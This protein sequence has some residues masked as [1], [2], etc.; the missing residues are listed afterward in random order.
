MEQ[1]IN[2]FDSSPKSG[3]QF[4]TIIITVAL[5]ALVVGGGIYW[6]ANQKQTE[7][8]NEIVSLRTQAEQL[9][10]TSSIAP[11]PVASNNQSDELVK[12]KF[13]LAILNFWQ[14][15]QVF[16]DPQ[17]KNKFYYV[18]NFDDG[19]DIWVYDLAKDKTYLQDGTFNF[20]IPEGNTLLLSQKL[21]KDQEFRGV[22]IVDNKF[23]FTEVF[24]DFSPGVCYS[25]WLY[26]SEYIDLGVSNPTRVSFIVP[27]DL[28]R[29]EEQ[30]VTDCEKNL[31]L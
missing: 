20:N 14:V 11:T 1:P 31:N 30:K 23:V 2:Q 18:T 28:K 15:R 22:G 25:P 16:Q 7:L 10:G 5:T 4:L 9:K 17:N 12:T 3:T 13:E 26:H 21:A 24:G 8:N 29:N 6:W 27:E 19:S